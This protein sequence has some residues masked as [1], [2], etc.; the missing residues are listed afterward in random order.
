MTIIGGASGRLTYPKKADRQ[1]T[2]QSNRMGYRLRGPALHHRAAA[3]I[4]SEATAPGSIQVPGNGQP[5][6]MCR[7]IEVTRA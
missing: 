5:A 6:P 7:E 4:L 1:V 3:D 2:P